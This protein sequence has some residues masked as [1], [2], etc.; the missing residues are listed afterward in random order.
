MLY[1]LLFYIVIDVI[2]GLLFNPSMPVEVRA[3]FCSC[4]SGLFV[5]VKW[6][7][8]FLPNGLC[9]HYPCPCYSQC[10]R[11]KVDMAAIADLL[12]QV[13]NLPIDFD[14]AR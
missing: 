1:K 3:C 13:I 2:F 10:F 11:T 14:D 8:F 5:C 12:K 7:L 4:R 9:F 6:F